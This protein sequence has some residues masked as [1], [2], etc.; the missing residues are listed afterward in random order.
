M[1]E[2][3]SVTGRSGVADG[4][5]SPIVFVGVNSFAG[6]QTAAFAGV[7]TALA[8]VGWRVAR[9]R[10]LRFALSGLLGTALAIAL[11]LRSGE[12]RDYFL[13]GLLSG[14]GTTALAIISIIARKPLTAWTSWVT[15]G[16]PIEWYWHPQV[17]PAYSLTTWLWAGFFGLRTAFQSWLFVTDQ[18]TALGIVRVITG[19]PGLFA[20]LLATYVIGR[21]RI[22]A[23]QGPSVEEFE[24]QAPPPWKGQQ[25]GF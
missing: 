16:W 15:R 20:L 22:Q 21:S 3:R 10:A 17:R 25:R 18:T 14:T 24:Q 23:L 19:W 11:A 13:P 1:D 5:V 2:I 6:V 8:I 9:G 12:A 7:G 4:V